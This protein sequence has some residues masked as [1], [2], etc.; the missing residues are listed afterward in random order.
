MPSNTGKPGGKRTGEKMADYA[1]AGGAF[2]AAVQEL[3]TRDFRISWLDRFPP[4]HA[5]AGL[6]TIGD[7]AE[8]E[9]AC[10]KLYV[11]LKRSREPLSFHALL[12]F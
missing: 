2:L 11:R 8:G 1:I 5:R 4:S 3:T 12:T 7:E 10:C 6:V 9:G